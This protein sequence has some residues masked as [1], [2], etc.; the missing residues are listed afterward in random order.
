VILTLDT[1]AALSTDA[2]GLQAASASPDETTD[3]ALFGQILSTQRAGPVSGSG[4]ADLPV[5]SQ[6]DA[7]G[8]TLL[9]GGG[10]EVP[11][12]EAPQIGATDPEYSLVLQV[13]RDPSANAL[14]ATETVEAIPAKPAAPLVSPP[15]VGLTDVEVSI[16]EKPVQSETQFKAPESALELPLAIGRVDLE[17]ESREVNPLLWGAPIV[18]SV[19]QSTVPSGQSVK[20][21]L[22]QPATGSGIGP[23]DTGVS[24]SDTSPDLLRKPELSPALGVSHSETLETLKPSDLAIPKSTP[25]NTAPVPP[26]I[27]QSVS[28]PTSSAGVRTSPVTTLNTPIGEP[29]WDQEFVG[30]IGVL[31]D[32]GL[33]EAKLQLTPA[34]LG[35]LEIKISTD[36]DQAKIVFTVQNATAREAIEQAMPRLRDMLGQEGLQLAHSEVADHSA[37]RDDDRN[38]NSGDLAT[39]LE[40]SEEEPDE[41][42]PRTVAVTPDTMV[43]YYV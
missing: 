9:P 16:E 32:K 5:S 25:P 36:G 4:V 29:S 43:D 37:A 3:S 12:L 18:T 22:R 15:G 13:D 28:E 23:S 7:A 1:P 33:S 8:G 24:G 30:R 6:P 41:F 39:S 17:T 14:S 34:E 26:A 10:K 19:L 42:L 20:S 2:Q 27:A 11:P 35:R 40:G 38:L 21:E 31:V